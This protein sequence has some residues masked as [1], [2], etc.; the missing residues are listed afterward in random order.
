MTAIV[1]I[2]DSELEGA[3]PYQR[4]LDEGVCTATIARHD[5]LEIDEP[6]SGP[7]DLLKITGDS[8]GPGL[9]LL[10]GDKVCVHTAV[11]FFPDYTFGD[12]DRELRNQ[13]FVAHCFADCYLT[14]IGTEVKV[15][16]PDPHQL[17]MADIFYVRDF[18]KPMEAE[19]W[20]QL[21]MIAH[22]VCGSFDLAM[23]AVTVL[24]L[25]DKIA[26]DAPDQ[27]QRILETL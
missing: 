25:Q 15:P 13:G 3:P 17:A 22:H 5:C 14:T 9:L 21:A 10:G 20:K 26:R 19:Q 1:E 18:R 6:P 11:S 7:I 24:A 27:Y 23:H 8:P 4:M 12:I 16:H 2:G